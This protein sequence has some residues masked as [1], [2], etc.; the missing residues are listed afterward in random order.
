MI[1]LSSCLPSSSVH[2]ILDPDRGWYYGDHRNTSLLG[3]LSPCLAISPSNISPHRE[4]RCEGQWYRVESR[5]SIMIWNL[6]HWLTRSASCFQATRHLVLIGRCH[7]SFPAWIDTACLDLEVYNVWKSCLSRLGVLW[8]PW[9][10]PLGTPSYRYWCVVK[11][12]LRDQV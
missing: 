4:A 9:S 12:K 1:Y 8:T 3:K 7:K 11:Q 5:W 2:R 6:H 10:G